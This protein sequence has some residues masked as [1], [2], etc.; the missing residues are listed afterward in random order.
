LNKTDYIKYIYLDIDGVLATT[1]QFYSK[2]RHPEW[3][4]YRFDKKCVDVLNE[5]L[6]KTNAF[7]ILSSDWKYHYDLETMNKIFEWNGIIR[8]IKEFTPSLWGVKYM[9]LDELD[10]C[11]AHEILKHVHENKNEI[12]AWVAIDDLNLHDLIANR[13]FVHTPRQNEG[14]KQTNIKTQILNRLL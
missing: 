9:S 2:K 7:I 14:I 6:E 13:N 10:Q 1:Q 11:R 12:A 4:C 8:P 3:N 5:I